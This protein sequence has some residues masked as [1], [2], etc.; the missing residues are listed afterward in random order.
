MP[1]RV[2]IIIIFIL[3]LRYSYSPIMGISF[4]SAPIIIF[5]YLLVLLS[6]TSSSRNLVN[7]VG[8]GGIGYCVV[9]GDIGFYILYCFFLTS[10]CFF[11]SFIL[12][13]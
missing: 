5:Y 6:I 3:I 7:S 13:L 11:R 9:S 1:S 2:L 4:I 12:S 10:L 8:I